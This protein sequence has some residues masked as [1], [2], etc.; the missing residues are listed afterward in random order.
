MKKPSPLQISLFDEQSDART[1]QERFW[2]G[3][4]T[5]DDMQEYKE[6]TLKAFNSP[7]AL[8][9]KKKNALAINGHP[10]NYSPDA[11]ALIIMAGKGSGFLGYVWV[12]RRDDAFRFMEHAKTRGRTRYGEWAYMVTT[13]QPDWRTFKKNFIVDDGRF[14][15]IFEELGIKIIYRNT[16]KQAKGGKKKDD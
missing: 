4:Y 13:A 14:D 6:Y 12:M 11:E 5:S 9:R 7:K 2:D 16:E 3:D 8:E 15:S 10:P 1:W